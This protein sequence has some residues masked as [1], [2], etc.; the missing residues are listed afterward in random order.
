V[1]I[2]T[3]LKMLVDISRTKE[4]VIVQE[5]LNTMYIEMLPGII[6]M[7]TKINDSYLQ[8]YLKEWAL[9]PRELKQDILKDLQDQILNNVMVQ[10]IAIVTNLHNQDKTTH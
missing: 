6:E 1:I 8:A 9:L 7:E 4:P 5:A 3:L 10:T 2:K